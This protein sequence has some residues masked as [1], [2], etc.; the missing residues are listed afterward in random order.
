[1]SCFIPSK[2][3]LGPIIQVSK[4]FAKSMKIDEYYLLKSNWTDNLLSE[5]GEICDGIK[6]MRQLVK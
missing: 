3:S 4:R 1:M 2:S 5:T 6:E